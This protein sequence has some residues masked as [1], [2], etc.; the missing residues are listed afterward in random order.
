MSSSRGKKDNNRQKSAGPPR[1]ERKN[2]RQS[3]GFYEQDIQEGYERAQRP[4]DTQKDYDRDWGLFQAPLSK[5]RKL[6][7][8]DDIRRGESE[9]SV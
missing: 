3:E 7:H 2:Q 5:I 8:G 4:Q 1:N 9:C 6:N